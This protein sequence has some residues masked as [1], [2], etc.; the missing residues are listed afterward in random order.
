MKRQYISFLF[1]AMMTLLQSISF[2]QSTLYR[3]I[4]TWSFNKALQD[5]DT[6]IVSTRSAIE[7][8]TAE[9]KS[10][11]NPQPVTIPVVF[12]VLNQDAL[13]PVTL[14]DAQE[15]VAVLNNCFAGVQGEFLHVADSLE[16]FGARK[17]NTLISFCLA[18]RDPAG[19]PTTGLN[20]E[21]TS[22]PMWNPGDTGIYHE[23]LGGAN[24][25]DVERYLNVWVTSMRDTITSY[26]QMPGGPVASDGIVMDNR[27]FG[28][29]EDTAWAYREGK[30]LV[31]LVGNYLNLYDL[32]GEGGLCSDDYVEDTPIHNAP[33][34][35]CNEIYRHVS[36]CGDNPVE[37][38]MNFMDNTDDACMYMFT[39]GQMM[40]MHAVLAE[41]GWRYGLVDSLNLACKPSDF[42]G[43]G[44]E[45][46]N[47]AE[48]T[49]DG[50]VGKNAMRL[51]PNPA[52]NEVNV[53]LRLVN[54]AKVVVT[55]F[56]TLGAV[57]QVE[58]FER[59]SGFHTLKLN[60]SAFPGGMYVVQA[61]VDGDV[62]TERLEVSGK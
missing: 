22:V 21:L 18:Q 41:G 45:E 19:A 3:N 5:V 13:S 1:L 27:Y 37:M 32:W 52:T 49:T 35:G 51:Y 12:H 38:T 14:A 9:Y 4:N 61:N 62:L 10:Y 25:W 2:C 7:R 39:Y 55:V 33:N 47:V 17:A 48:N 54:D 16:G 34:Y 15:Q 46:R 40:R 50:M 26:A 6:N 11:G 58:T 24:A 59:T 30:T 8:F 29:I 56:N 57:Q 28:V 53:A 44:L 60:C 36:T 31:H 42:A 23:E 20:L 43:Q